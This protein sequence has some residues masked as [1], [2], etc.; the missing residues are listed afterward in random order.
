[1]FLVST[2]LQLP[3]NHHSAPFYRSRCWHLL[4]WASRSN[5]KVERVFA[6]FV[7][8]WQKLCQSTPVRALYGGIYRHSSDHPSLV[9]DVYALEYPVYPQNI[10]TRGGCKSYYKCGP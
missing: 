9:K 7:V 5:G 8:G 4:S 10:S 1:M 3:T 6:K 2:L